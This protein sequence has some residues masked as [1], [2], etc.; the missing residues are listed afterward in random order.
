MMCVRACVGVQIS[1]YEDEH[2][3]YMEV[4]ELLKEKV[5]TLES[6]EAKKRLLEQQYAH[7]Q[8]EVRLGWGARWGGEVGGRGLVV[9]P[10]LLG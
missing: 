4:E 7:T 6:L 9:G 3:R 1:L 10:R 2:L 8:S 5:L